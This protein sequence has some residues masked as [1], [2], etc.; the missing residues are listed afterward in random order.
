MRRTDRSLRHHLLLAPLPSSH[1]IRPS[2]HEKRNEPR[3]YDIYIFFEREKKVRKEEENISQTF[4]KIF[5]G[6]LLIPL[7]FS[8]SSFSFAIEFTFTEKLSARWKKWRQPPRRLR[9]RSWL[10]G[11][12]NSR[13]NRPGRRATGRKANAQA[14]VQVQAARQIDEEGEYPSSNIA[15]YSFFLFF[16]LPFPIFFSIQYRSNVVV[17]LVFRSKEAVLRNR[18][19]ARKK[20]KTRRSVC[21]RNRAAN[22]LN[23]IGSRLLNEN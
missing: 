22:A 2:L 10:P 16:L 5:R 21:E 19:N 9:G 17:H 1:F 7:F 12:V 6:Y 15:R 4:R 3:C 11:E 13:K 8:H 20:K 14:S 23:G 18:F